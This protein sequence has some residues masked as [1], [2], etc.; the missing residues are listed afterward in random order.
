MPSY[1]RRQQ[2]SNSDNLVFLTPVTPTGGN[3]KNNQFRHQINSLPARLNKQPSP[4]PFS[5]FK[6]EQVISH[7][8]SH[9]RKRRGESSATY[10]KDLV[11]SFDDEPGCKK[12]RSFNPETVP[13]QVALSYFDV[14]SYLF[15]LFLLL[16]ACVVSNRQL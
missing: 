12:R 8:A 10:A 11:P 3:R 1:N 13:Q 2:N 5:N 4:F 14:V 15:W 6:N 9:G 7:S 16:F